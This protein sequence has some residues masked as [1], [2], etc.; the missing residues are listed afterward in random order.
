MLLV[1]ILVEQLLCL[2]IP[3]VLFALVDVAAALL[4]D[5]LEL[6]ELVLQLLDVLLD[7]L[8]VL[9]KELVAGALEG[10]GVVDFV[11]DVLRL[12]DVLVAGSARLQVL[13]LDCFK[14]VVVYY[15]LLIESLAEGAGFALLF[16]KGH[17]LNFQRFNF[18]LLSRKL[19][20]GLMQFIFELVDDELHLGFFR[21]HQLCDRYRKHDLALVW[22][23]RLG[24]ER[25]RSCWIK[26]IIW[27]R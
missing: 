1:L 21:V 19:L 26:P 10:Q 8:L 25:A 17:D 15:A 11:D 13:V 6:G 20:L 14:I 2:F 23:D 5:F 18:G 27:N 22:V 24:T 12:L 16:V 4:D 9:F 3:G 7:E